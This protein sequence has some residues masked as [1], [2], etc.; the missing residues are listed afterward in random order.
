VKV[1]NIELRDIN[2]LMGYRDPQLYIKDAWI[3]FSVRNIGKQA[4]ACHTFMASRTIGCLEWQ[5]CCLL[6]ASSLENKPFNRSQT[7][8]V[9][10]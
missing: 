9:L 3:G 7:W 5:N 1:T 10:H 2:Q 6:L 4:V 8:P